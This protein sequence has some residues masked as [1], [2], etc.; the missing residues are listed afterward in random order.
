MPEKGLSQ[1]FWLEGRSWNY[2][3]TFL[4]VTIKPLKIIP[5]Q[6]CKWFL[7]YSRQRKKHIWWI[8]DDNVE[9][10]FHFFISILWIYTMDIHKSASFLATLINT[11]NICFHGK[12]KEIILYHQKATVSVSLQSIEH[13]DRSI[14]F[15]KIG[16]CFMW[17]QDLWLNTEQIDVYP[18]ESSI[19]TASSEFG[20]YRLCEERRFRRACA[21]AQSRQN[22][23]WSLI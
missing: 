10:I 19:W 15:W 14:K 22:L 9:I 2:R 17:S 7:W 1:W 23:R 12:L 20:T 4:M 16:Y 21:S 3:S 11:K 8:F 6:W 13:L 5:F 18:K